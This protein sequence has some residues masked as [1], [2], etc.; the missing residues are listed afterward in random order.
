[1]NAA[2]LP[3]V[4]LVLLVELAV[5]STV[6]LAI[7]DGRRQVT[8][9]YVKAGAI[10]ALVL[11]ILGAWTYSVLT[12]RSGSTEVDGYLLRPD[13]L[14]PFLIAFSGYLL[15]CGAHTILSL[16]ERQRLRVLVAS[17]ASVV[18]AVAV[19]LLAG[20]FAAPAWSLPGM[21]ASMLVATL[22]LGAG[23]MA[24]TWGHWYLTSGRLPKE[25]MVQ[26]SLLLLVALVAQTLLVI[27]GAVLPV[28]HV[29]LSEGAFGVS[30]AANPAFWLRVGVGLV[31]PIGAT[32]LAYKSAQIHGMMS[33]TG[34][35]YIALGAVL[36]G[37]VLS[38]A[39]L[40]STGNLV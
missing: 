3:Y 30:L 38:R 39:L 22:V 15:L 31:F 14:T 5:G 10:M 34:L 4:V 27:L 24:M 11:G 18:G 1:M 29:P 6:M 33:A 19:V 2:S 13:W 21:I 23:L 37:E 12:G 35:L 32:A 25:P 40:F 17:A 9:G 7:F 28:R 20:Y 36:A 8:D 16:Q 26:M